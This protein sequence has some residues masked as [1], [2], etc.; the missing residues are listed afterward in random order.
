MSG[1]RRDIGDPRK[2]R[3]GMT[4]ILCAGL[5]LAALMVAGCSR[6]WVMDSQPPE[7]GMV[8][9]QAPEKPRVRHLATITGFRERG[10]SFKSLIFGKGEDRIVNPVAVAAGGDGRIAVADTGSRSV[11]LYI[12][13]EE[14]YIGVFRSGSGDHRRRIK[15]HQP[16]IA[17]GRINIVISYASGDRFHYCPPAAPNFAH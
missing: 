16:S 13:K 7:A 1:A 17:Q 3:N 6:K 10:V 9:P 15:N 2:M 4:R 12:P 5:C 14:R 11:H 8:W